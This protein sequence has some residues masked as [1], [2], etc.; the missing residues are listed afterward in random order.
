M[1]YTDPECMAVI[2]RRDKNA[3]DDYVKEIHKEVAKELKVIAQKNKTDPNYIT[4]DKYVKR[5]S[6]LAAKNK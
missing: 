3:N 5:S 6:R 1:V 4:E 2:K